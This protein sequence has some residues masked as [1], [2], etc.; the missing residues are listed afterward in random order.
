MASKDVKLDKRSRSRTA[1]GGVG[2]GAC[3]ALP[4]RHEGVSRC[5]QTTLTSR[6]GTGPVSFNDS[7]NAGLLILKGVSKQSALDHSPRSVG[8]FP[9]AQLP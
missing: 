4:E 2:D 7:N 3:F 9:L 6:P 8:P 1:R 5:A